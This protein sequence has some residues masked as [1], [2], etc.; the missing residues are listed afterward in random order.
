MLFCVIACKSAALKPIISRCAKYVLSM[1]MDGLRLH[2]HSD[3]VSGSL[4]NSWAAEVHVYQ[5]SEN[6]EY[7]LGYREIER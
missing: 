4:G 5:M 1:G 6:R 2:E 7:S 3:K